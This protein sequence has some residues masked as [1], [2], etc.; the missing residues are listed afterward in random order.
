[1]SM[2]SFLKKMDVKWVQAGSQYFYFLNRDKSETIGTFASSKIPNAKQFA[3]SV[4]YSVDEFIE[5]SSY[6]FMTKQELD[7]LSTL[8]FV[9]IT[10]SNNKVEV[11]IDIDP[12][13]SDS[14]KVFY[15]KNDMYQD[16]DHVIRF[17]RFMFPSLK[18]GDK[19]YKEMI[20]FGERTS[21][22]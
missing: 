5:I 1:M 2:K 3:H 22:E 18:E 9:C 6:A 11:W 4:Y 8:D 12:K 19:F 15:T 10:K 7:I 21:S 17:P 14:C 20:Y 13:W 16:I